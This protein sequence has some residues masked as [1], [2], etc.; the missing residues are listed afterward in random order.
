MNNAAGNFDVRVF[1]WTYVFT[2][3]GHIPRSGSAVSCGNV[4]LLLK[5][6]C[7]HKHCISFITSLIELIFSLYQMESENIIS[8]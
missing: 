5:N 1:V 7:P 6:I 4:L 3:L 2:S 8:C